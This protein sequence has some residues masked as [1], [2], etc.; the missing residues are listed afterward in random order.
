MCNYYFQHHTNYTVF[1]LSSYQLMS[2]WMDMSGPCLVDDWSTGQAGPSCLEDDWLAG[3]AEDRCP[4]PLN[5]VTDEV[6]F[7]AEL[8][9]TSSVKL[10]V[11]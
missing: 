6:K 8:R 10:Y 9:E 11:L 2:R 4:S 7:H 1:L 5:S 3:Q